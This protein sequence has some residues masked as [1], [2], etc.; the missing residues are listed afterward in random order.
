MQ[1]N[2][3]RL[4]AAVSATNAHGSISASMA[5]VSA[6]DSKPPAAGIC[7]WATAAGLGAGPRRWS[8][9]CNSTASPQSSLALMPPL[10]SCDSDKTRLSSVRLGRTLLV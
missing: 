6:T 10:R 2:G 7:S 5:A 9:R 4:L 8:W 3:A 1:L